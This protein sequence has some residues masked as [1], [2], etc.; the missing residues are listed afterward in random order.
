MLK[1]YDVKENY[2]AEIPIEKIV[3]IK[4]YPS[5][6]SVLIRVVDIWERINIETREIG[7]Q[8]VLEWNVYT[9]T[10]FNGKI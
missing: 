7:E 6:P 3:Y 10:K 2:F 4:Y 8:I 9:R 5:D 1:I